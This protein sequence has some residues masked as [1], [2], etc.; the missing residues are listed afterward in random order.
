MVSKAAISLAFSRAANHYDQYAVL[1]REITQRLFDHLIPIRLSP[2]VILDAGSGTG[3]A[4]V[5]LKKY[6]KQAQLLELDLSLDMLKQARQRYSGNSFFHLVAKL[7]QFILRN[8]K[9]PFQICGDIEALPLK[10]R[11][12]DFI[13]S[14]LAFQWCSSYQTVF[15]ECFRV[16]RPGGLLLFATLGPDTLKEL[17]YAFSG[18]DFLN[19]HAWVDMHHLGDCL[20]QTGFD[21]P[22]MDVEYLTLTYTDLLSIVRDLKAVGAN[23]TDYHPRLGNKQIWR[24]ARTRYETFRTEAVLPVTYEVVFGHAWKP[25]SSDSTHFSRDW[26]PIHFYP[27]S[28]VNRLNTSA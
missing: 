16:L 1:Q 20:L 19:Q 28:S 15:S 12:I 22:V 8:H 11:S 4:H 6:F 17:R 24:Q 10:D 13:W 27:S 5:L 2:Q 25:V 3:Y 9:I 23:A 14:S 26:Q 18:T 21:N 7:R